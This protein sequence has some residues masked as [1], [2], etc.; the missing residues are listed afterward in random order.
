MVLPCPLLV[1]AS[2]T[3]KIWALPLTE[4]WTEVAP[5]YSGAR[6]QAGQRQVRRVELPKVSHF[7]LLDHPD[8]RDAVTRE[9]A[10]AARGVV[11]L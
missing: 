4:R 6:A 11:G 5:A 9:M 3:D 10:A 1:L 8:V 2:T 7:K